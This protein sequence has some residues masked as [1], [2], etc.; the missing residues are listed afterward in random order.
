MPRRVSCRGGL[1]LLARER[2][3][4][5]GGL[6]GSAMGDTPTQLF[7]MNDRLIEFFGQ[8]ALP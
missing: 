7:N 1:G 3:A 6:Q 4:W 5:P 2:D 8:H